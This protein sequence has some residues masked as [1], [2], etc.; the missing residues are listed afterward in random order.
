[1][2]LHLPPDARHKLTKMTRR[3]GDTPKR[4]TDA[5][6]PAAPGPLS[7]PAAARLSRSTII[8]GVVSLLSDISTEMVYPILPI[9]IR[10]VLKAPATALGLIE[11]IAN[12]TASVVTGFSGRISDR[13]GK[14]KPVALT[15]Y[16]LTALSKP[17]IAFAAVWPLVLGAR[18]A[19]RLGKGVRSAPKDAMVADSAELASRGRAFGFERMM[20][21]TGAVLGPLLGLALFVG[22]GAG[23]VRMIFLLSAIPA[24]MAALLILAVRETPKVLP[25]S[26]RPNRL[27]LSAATPEYKRFLIASGVFGLANSANAFLILRS[28]SLGMNAR[29]TILAY[30]LYN[31]VAALGSMP[32]GA[33]S[34]RLGRRNLLI[35]GYV[36]Y[37][38]TYAGFA[39]AREAWVVWPLFATY[40]L[41]AALTDGVGKSLAVDT[42]G[43]AGRATAI[44]VYSM[45]NGVTQVAASFLAGVLWDRVF[46]AA[47]FYVGGSLALAAGALLL[48]LPGHPRRDSDG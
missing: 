48:T 43:R 20:D 8:I 37:A 44:G 35:V 23:R 31:A 36:I 14:R 22:L 21:Y 38:V 1:M 33:A 2:V 4:R 15:G 5:D 7:A 10:D 24:T 13:L 42:A 17:L 25:D 28:Q 34:D 46:P 40:G 12:G 9:F 29:W 26:A 47:V 18:F 30:A 45:V 41:F 16:G 27:T 6:V 32:A 11:G 3:D 39:L 19:D